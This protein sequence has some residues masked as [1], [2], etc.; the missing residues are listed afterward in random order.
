MTRQ[1]TNW[2]VKDGCECKG[3]NCGTDH[4]FG[5]RK[6]IMSSKNEKIN[7]V[8]QKMKKLQDIMYNL[9]GL[10]CNSIQNKFL[11]W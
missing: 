3:R 5:Q 4:F 10:K 6:N 7:W 1:E 2:M 11:D 8:N 9:Q